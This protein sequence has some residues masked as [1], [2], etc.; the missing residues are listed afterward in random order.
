MPFSLGDLSI[1]WVYLSLLIGLIGGGFNFDR[2]MERTRRENNKPRVNQF[3]DN[4]LTQENITSSR[5]LSCFAIKAIV[6]GFKPKQLQRLFNSPLTFKTKV[7][8]VTTT[9]WDKSPDTPLEGIYEVCKGN[10]NLL[11]E[12]IDWEDTNYVWQMCK[13]EFDFIDS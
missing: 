4:Q 7:L 11:S 5:F 3:L 2:S 1:S 8:L 9:Y 12:Q 13:K 6:N 10:Q